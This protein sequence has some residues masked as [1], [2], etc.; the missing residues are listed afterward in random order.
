MRLTTHN[1]SAIPNPTVTLDRPIRVRLRVDEGR[2][3]LALGIRET[4]TTV[5]IGQDGGTAGTIEWVGVADDVDGAPQGVLVEPNPGVWQTFIFDPLTDPIH[6][7]TGDG[8]L[9]TETN[10]G[11]FEH[12]AFAIVDT[13]GPFTVYI[14]DIDLLCGMPSFGDLNH[15]GEVDIADFILFEL[16]LLGPGVTVGGDCPEADAEGDDDVDLA[17]FATFQR[18]FGT[19]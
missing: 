11:V 14:D 10:K 17:D 15:D 2:F 5:D 18:A 8:V 13:V 3:R 16:C 19:P 9:W 6:G 12:L 4:G 1:A 7:M